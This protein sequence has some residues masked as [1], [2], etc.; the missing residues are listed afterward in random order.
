MARAAAMLLFAIVSLLALRFASA[1]T[2]LSERYNVIDLWQSLGI[3]SQEPPYIVQ[4]GDTLSGI[5]TTYAVSL[6]CL[7][8]L[9]P[10][11]DDPDLIFP[12]DLVN[13]P[14]SNG[15][16]QYR[17]L[18]G[19][20]MAA[21]AEQ[22]HIP[23]DALIVANPQVADPNLIF[24]GDVLNVPSICSR[25]VRG[26]S[27]SCNGTLYPSKDVSPGPWLIVFQRFA[28]HVSIHVSTVILF[29]P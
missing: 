21:I 5:A 29:A 15:T 1:R 9:N 19:D 16:V 4:S 25:M 11:I 12:D 22:F 3:L 13:I 2:P 10:Q 8:A 20:F 26:A 7:V 28:K 6:Q 17:V 27:F 14:A 18:P 23:L 24:P